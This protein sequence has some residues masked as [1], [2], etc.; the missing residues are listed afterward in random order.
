MSFFN[1]L[2]KN[3]AAVSKGLLSVVL[4]VVLAV[5]YSGR[6]YGKEELSTKSWV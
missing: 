6:A 4:S 5:V 1:I 3:G 2:L